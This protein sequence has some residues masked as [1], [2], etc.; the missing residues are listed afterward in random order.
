[1]PMTAQAA[2][3]ADDTA[4]NAQPTAADNGASTIR[5]NG[6]TSATPFVIIGSGVT[7]TGD[8]VVP[9]TEVLEITAPNYSVTVNGSLVGTNHDGIN[10]TSAFNL[11]ANTGFIRGVGAGRQG[12]E[13][14]G[15]TSSL[16]S[17][18]TISGTDDAI[19][20]TTNG[21]IVINS[22]LIDGVTGA[23]SDGIEG[24]V[25]VS[26]TNNSGGTIRGADQGIQVTTGLTLNNNLG[27]SVVG[28]ANDGVFATSATAINNYGGI[29]GAT[30]GV[31]VSLGGTISNLTSFDIFSNPIAGGSIIGSNGAGITATSGLI[32]V[33][34]NLGT[35]SGTTNGINAGATALI[36]NTAGASITGTA[37]NGITATTGLVLGNGGT[38]TGSSAGIS[39]GASAT[40]TNNAG[41]SITGSDDSGIRAGDLANITNSGTVTGDEYGINLSTTTTGSVTNNAGGLITS[42]QYGILGGA[43]VETVTNAGT[44]TGTGIFDALQLNGGANVINLND[45]SVINGPISASG[46]SNTINIDGGQ[47]SLGDTTLNLINGAVNNTTLINKTGAGTA[48]ITGNVFAD[49]IAVTGGALYINGNVTN[50]AILQNTVSVTGA[51]LGGTGFWN[52]AI[53]LATGAGISPG[54]APISIASPVTSAVGTLSNSGNVTLDATS[55]YRWDINPSTGAFDQIALTGAGVFT[56]NNSGFRISPTSVNAP[57]QDGSR[58]VVDTASALVGNFGPIT[59]SPVTANT[60]NAG[61]FNPNYTNPIL[62]NNF[63]TLTQVSGGQDWQ[64]SIVHDYSQFGVTEN[65]V[66]AGVMLNGLVSTATGDV[67][68]LLA[69]MDLSNAATTTNVLAALDP[70]AYLATTSAIASNNYRLH[71][72]VETHN[73][74]VRAGSG[75]TISSSS[76]GYSSSKGGTASTSSNSYVGGSNVWGSAAYDWQNLNTEAGDFDTDGE[77]GSFTAGIDFTVANNFRLG[78]VAEGSRTSWD[79][80][81][82]SD[83]TDVDSYRVGLYAN[84]GEST[85]WFVDA[86]VGYNNH[87][88]DQDRSTSVAGIGSTLGSSYD[89]DGWQGLLTVGHTFDISAGLL[90]PFVGVEWQRL[91]VDGFTESDAVLPLSVSDYDVDSLR[92]LAG[93]KWEMGVG[94]GLALYATAAYAHEFE[95]DSNDVTVSFAGSSY[96]AT[97]LDQN[98]SVLLSAGIRWAASEATTIDI[99]YR[100]EVGLDDDG[101]DSHGA[102][103][104]I[105]YSF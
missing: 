105:N 7:L 4:G 15:G 5:A 70:G 34:Q 85:G 82:G 103:L 21:G 55:F 45:G 101:L 74:A 38:I 81:N 54:S 19:R 95:D 6:G 51:A 47:A 52:S 40:I 96:T 56:T 64:L 63:A 75:S 79:S 39:A 31:N 46:G 24:L 20:F 43:G 71:R 77:T 104:G 66:A 14:L 17:S 10:A 41:G 16:T 12:I 97:G 3:F 27:A 13:T 42:N 44:I 2:I 89:A 99:G 65:Q 60:P 50:T 28:L 18:G 94:D 67:A 48:F 61:P 57:I 100:G 53:T 72:S 87:S 9:E 84:Y 32:F 83:G 90:S 22:G 1:M 58:L 37:G 91:S 11:L 80:D 78:L 92:G 73:A 25:G 102:N 59:I 33:N 76:G 23:G 93:I 26:V 62:A 8:T 30:N 86:L 49:T 98:D 35:V 88:V 29:T 36:N 68:D 69:A